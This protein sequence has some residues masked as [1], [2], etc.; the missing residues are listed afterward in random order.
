MSSVV[1][2]S[3]IIIVRRRAR[4][5]STPLRCARNDTME[6]YLSINE[7]FH[8]RPNRAAILRGYPA[9]I[10]TKNNASKG[11]CVTVT[12]RG[13][14]AS[15]FTIFDGATEVATG[16]TKNLPT[17]TKFLLRYTPKRRENPQKEKA[18]RLRRA[19]AYQEKFLVT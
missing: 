7:T 9:W 8:S 17:R 5:S 6:G 3:L 4:D 1:E 10:R 12:P 15:R 14:S 2:T 19:F 11:R 18:L 16:G 13:K